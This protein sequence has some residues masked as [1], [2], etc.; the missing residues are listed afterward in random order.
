MFI[1]KAKV[2]TLFLESAFAMLVLIHLLY[3]LCVCARVGHAGPERDW[4]GGGAQLGQRGAQV[5]EP[6][7][8]RVQE[9]HPHPEGKNWP[10]AAVHKVPQ[11]ISVSHRL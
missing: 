6:G 1:P 8:P 3:S 11:G 9:H 10:P 2:C 7:G 4:L 5:G